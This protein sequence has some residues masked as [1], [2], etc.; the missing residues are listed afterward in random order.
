MSALLLAC[1][2][3][4]TV[5]PNGPAPLSPG[6]SEAFGEFIRTHDIVLAYASGR[7]L[8]L[9]EQ[10]I[11]EFAV[12]EP[13]V[14]V[15]DVGTTMYTR[16]GGAWQRV[17]AWQEKLAHDWGGK[18]GGDIDALVRDIGGLRPQEPGKQGTYKQ[19]Y[20]TD[21]SADAK[22]LIASVQTALEPAGIQANVVCSIDQV[23]D[24]GLLDILPRSASK[25]SAL[26]YLQGMYALPH[27]QVV[28]AGDSGND[29]EALVSGYFAILVGNALP[30]LRD[31]V[32][33][34]ARENGIGERLYCA[35]GGY[36]GY[37]G[38]YTAGILE[39]LDH[40]SRQGS[41]RL[42]QRAV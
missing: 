16:A 8:R 15:G 34:L 21:A 27:E 5:L 42:A 30:A 9:V 33:E 19:S 29:T 22:A 1:D 14:I 12:P 40:F 26:A 38:N 36:Q 23:A 18:T 2:M 11:A 41:I 13:A 20:Y 25:A 6:A 37:N 10:G 28:F 7:D 17:T 3:D 32:R 4:R 24:V 35:T 31:E 39:G